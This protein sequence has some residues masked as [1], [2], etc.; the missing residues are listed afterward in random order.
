MGGLEAATPAPDKAHGESRAVIQRA[1]STALQGIMGRE[2]K[3]VRALGWKPA[4]DGP[5][6]QA[7]GIES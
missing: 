4:L 2:G 7:K 1:V 5:S 3:R 6:G